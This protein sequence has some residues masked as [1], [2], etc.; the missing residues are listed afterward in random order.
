MPP[1]ST[2]RALLLL[3][4]ACVLGLPARLHATTLKFAK[5]GTFD[6]VIL[7][8]N[9]TNTVVMG[10][11]KDGKH[12]TVTLSSLEE[13]SRWSVKTSGLFSY[14]PPADAPWL[15]DSIWRSNRE[16]IY[17]LKAKTLL[18]ERKRQAIRDTAKLRKEANQ[19]DAPEQQQIN[20]LSKELAD[21]NSRIAAYETRQIE[22]EARH[23]LRTLKR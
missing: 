5:G 14:T 12:Y 22:I 9:D 2:Q 16:K 1:H 10:N 19:S 6:G 13:G 3:L 8:F 20:D 21:L 4:A 11:P 7:G 23:R 15:K 18:V 17:T